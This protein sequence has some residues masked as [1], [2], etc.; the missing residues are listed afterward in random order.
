MEAMSVSPCIVRPQF[1]RQEVPLMSTN[2]AKMELF[3]VSLLQ[4]IWILQSIC[5]CHMLPKSSLTCSWF[6]YCKACVSV[7]C[8]Q[9]L[10]WL[11]LILLK[12]F[13]NTSTV[14]LIYPYTAI[15]SYSMSGVSP[16]VS[17]FQKIRHNF[18]LVWG[19]HEANAPFDVNQKLLW[20]P[21]FFAITRCWT[22]YS[23][24][25]ALQLKTTPRLPK[26]RVSAC[27]WA[28]FSHKLK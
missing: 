17:S 16:E 6:R 28:Y 27:W 2:Q 14:M 23:A 4:L 8:C 12:G 19:L 20:L 7:L 11:N 5:C 3:I 13:W 1:A 24:M 25:M 18:G 15:F 10:L 21:S 22:N 26:S 9:K